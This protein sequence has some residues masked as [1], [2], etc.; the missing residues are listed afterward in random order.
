MT[1]I[2]PRLT[3]LS[4]TILQPFGRTAL[5]PPPPDTPTLNRVDPD[6]GGLILAPAITPF[7]HP[8]VHVVRKGREL[9][10]LIK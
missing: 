10:H 9:G 6:A 4:S 5:A 3:A 7:P 2:G 8:A 1:G